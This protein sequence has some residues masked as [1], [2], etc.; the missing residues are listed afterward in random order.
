[1]MAEADDV[2][3]TVMMAKV[4]PQ[5]G[6]RCLVKMVTVARCIKMRTIV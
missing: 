5:V 1:M 2:E 6:A 4:I 3:M